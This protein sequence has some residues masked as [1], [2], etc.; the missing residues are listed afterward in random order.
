[1]YVQNSQDIN[2][3]MLNNYAHWRNFHRCLLL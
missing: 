2:D 1:M 3:A